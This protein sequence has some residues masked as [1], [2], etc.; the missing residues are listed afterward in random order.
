MQSSYWGYFLV[1][2]GVAIVGLSIAVN[3]LTTTST[4]NNYEIKKN[5]KKWL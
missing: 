2:L 5:M 4:E 1:T 3:G